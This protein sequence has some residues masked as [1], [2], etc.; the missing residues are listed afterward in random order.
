MSWDPD[1]RRTMPDTAQDTLT[2]LVTFYVRPDVMAQ[3]GRGTP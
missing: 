1:P 3:T 2:S